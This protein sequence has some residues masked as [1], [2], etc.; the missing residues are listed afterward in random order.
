[1]L[2][3]PK[4]AAFLKNLR[5]VSDRWKQNPG[6]YEFLGETPLKHFIFVE[7][8]RTWDQFSRWHRTL[9]GNWGF[10]G[11]ANA[12]WNLDP[13]IDRL[14]FVKGKSY[15]RQL[16][17]W[18]YESDLLFKYQ[19][20]AHQFIAHPPPMSDR[21]SWLA[22]M[23]HHGVPTRFL[24][25]TRSPYAASYFAFHED[26][27]RSTANAAIWA[28]DLDQ[29]EKRG[30][31]ALQKYTHERIPEDPRRR[32]KYLN[33]L[34]SRQLRSGPSGKEAPPMVVRVE[35]QATDPW[36]TSQMGFFLCK[37]YSRAS[38][39]LLLM[40]MMIHPD[41]IEFPLVRKLEIPRGLRFPFLKELNNMN[42]NHASLFPSLDGFSTSL[43]INLTIC[44]DEYRQG[45][46]AEEAAF[47]IKTWMEARNQKD[48]QEHGISPA[49]QS[50]DEPE[51]PD[52]D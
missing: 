7:K 50:E 3:D 10:R 11:Q 37:A 22:L 48:A 2:N 47:D 35:P 33:R 41:L 39:N 52:S 46:E 15:G 40:T 6:A 19:Q 25:W 20:Q 27:P 45:I 13:S 34:L 44:L 29:L 18:P 23:Q 17:Y 36:M 1:M 16:D 43:R 49:N 38:F 4:Y 12:K 5:E 9:K 21:M 8:A 51:P 26:L 14:T 42:V 32:S 28:I 30:N 31:A 24:D